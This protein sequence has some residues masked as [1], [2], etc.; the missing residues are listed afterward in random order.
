VAGAAVVFGMI[1]PVRAANTI[2]KLEI[3]EDRLAVT[4][5]RTGILVAI[6]SK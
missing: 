3:D 2:E 1:T 6:W 5:R 4:P